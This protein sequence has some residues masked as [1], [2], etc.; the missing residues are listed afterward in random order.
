MKKIIFIISL[1]AIIILTST[2]I[3][4]EGQEKP[5]PDQIFLHTGSP[6]ILSEDKIAPLD[7][8]NLDV[9]ATVINSRTLLPLRAIGEYFGAEVSYDAQ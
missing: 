4:A 9:A 8:E 3:P 5:L 2:A 6:L 1:V 7:P